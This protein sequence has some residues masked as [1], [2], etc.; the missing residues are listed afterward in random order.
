M[1]KGEKE[2]GKLAT[3]TKTS[4]KKNYLYNLA[5]QILAILV[6]LVTTPYVSR[7]LG[8]KGLGDFA[9]TGANVSYFAM[10]AALGTAT[11]AQREVA[12]VQNDPE[13]RSRVFWEILLLRM[14]TTSLVGMVYYYSFCRAGALRN[15][16][17]IRMLMVLSW[18]L[19]ICWF[20]QG[21]E[22]F[23][24]T[25]MRNALVK[26]VTVALIFLF[27]RTEE[28][29][30]LYTLLLSGTILAGTLT[31]WPF[32]KK[33]LV[34]IDRKRI[35]PLR[36]L[37]GTLELFVPVIGI[38]VYTVL[39]QTMLGLLTD[40]TQVGYYFQAEKIV[41]LVST[42]LY[43][44]TAVLLPR[45]SAVIGGKKWELAREYYQKTVCCSVLLILPMLAGCMFTAGY[46]IPVFLGQAYT[47]CILLLQIFSLLFITQGIG[48][49]AGTVLLALKKQK[50]YTRAVMSG[51][52]LNLAMNGIL[53]PRYGAVGATMASV[54]SELCVELLMLRGL[55]P[56]FSNRVLVQAICHY[57]PPTLIMCAGLWLA[58]HFLVQVNPGS[59][60]LMVG[61]G[62]AIYGG[63]L[64]SCR[65][66]YL[67]ELLKR[68]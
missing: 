55:R 15:L 51:A 14:L 8:P 3:E 59:L 41:K 23:R 1:A 12:F 7:V 40:T 53:I 49:I 45:M 61:L 66:R 5:Y 39:D 43:A 35:D 63:V 37:R 48:Q 52:A 19:D 26:L 27:V 65:D 4:V 54:L 44:L 21:M 68:N 42:I 29:V 22:N 31:M 62:M 2:V 58:R 57:L 60:L 50:S 46:L 25:V 9:F 6:P 32:L 11:Y 10:F 36:H 17:G 20:F 33:Y 38:Q 16:Y 13:E 67:M 30:G 34:R 18:A 56:E 47:P 24:V 28:D 64:L